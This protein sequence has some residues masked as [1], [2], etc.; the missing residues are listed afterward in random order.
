MNTPSV[1]LLYCEIHSTLFVPASRFTLLFPVFLSSLL[2]P[3]TFFFF[4][5]SLSLLLLYFLP[6]RHKRRIYRT[7]RNTRALPRPRRV[8]FALE[9]Y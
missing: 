5:F 3:S 1:W 4:Y 2:A 9:N 6:R 8:C 7:R